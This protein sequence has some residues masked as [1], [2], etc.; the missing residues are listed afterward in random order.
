[1]ALP[2]QP[3]YSGSSAPTIFWWDNF[4]RFIDT[5][6]GG[7]SIHNTPGIAFQEQSA[8]TDIKNLVSTDQREP[9]SLANEQ[10]PPLKR[11][12][13]DPKKNPARVLV[14][15]EAQTQRVYLILAMYST[16]GKFY[17]RKINE[18]IQSFV[19]V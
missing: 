9:T 12:K 3:K 16:Y 6:T 2:I 5:G 11:F 10:G 7:G 8:D 18:T 13:M 15:M 19:D 14:M 17:E 4:Y 1:M